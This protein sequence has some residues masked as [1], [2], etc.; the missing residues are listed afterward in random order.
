MNKKAFFFVLAFMVSIS[1]SAQTVVDVALKDLIHK[2]IAEYI[3][4]KIDGVGVAEGLEKSAY[5]T[6][7]PASWFR[8]KTVLTDGN[9]FINLTVLHLSGEEKKATQYTFYDAQTH[10]QIAREQ[11]AEYIT[12]TYFVT[13][14]G[15][16]ALRISMLK[17]KNSDVA[18][19]DV[20]FVMINKST[21][22]TGTSAV[23]GADVRE[24]DKVF[25]KYRKIFDYMVYSIYK[26]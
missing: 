19:M 10:Q 18:Y 26:R 23:A 13:E 7:Y 5:A 12:S 25:P 9:S 21:F 24:L 3:L 16:K 20:Y 22:V 2:N 1:L 4:P 6:S 11:G 8:K 17:T 15:W 14:M